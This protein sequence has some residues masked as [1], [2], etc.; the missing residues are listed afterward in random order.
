MSN[1]LPSQLTGQW[2]LVSLRNPVS[3]AV[4]FTVKYPC[5][6][7]AIADADRCIRPDMSPSKASRVC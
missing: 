4:I 7:R 1:V 5:E 2:W 6:Y 3:G